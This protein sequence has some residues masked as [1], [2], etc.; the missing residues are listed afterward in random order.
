MPKIEVEKL[1]EI[2]VPRDINIQDSVNWF[3]E[4]L[5]QSAFANEE[6]KREA[7]KSMLNEA[8]TKAKAVERREV[9]HYIYQNPGSVE[10]N[11]K[12]W[13]LRYGGVYE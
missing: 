3:F 4:H 7:L 9:A 13:D 11:K 2:M 5:L 10:E 12:Y 1:K 8:I 6:T